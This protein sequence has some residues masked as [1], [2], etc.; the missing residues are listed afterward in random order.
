MHSQFKNVEGLIS[1]VFNHLSGDFMNGKQKTIHPF[2]S[3]VTPVV[4]LPF[5]FFLAPPPFVFRPFLHCATPFDTE[6]MIL[7]AWT[8]TAESGGKDMSEHSP[9]TNIV[10]AAIEL[11]RFPYLAPRRL[12]VALRS[13]GQISRQ[14]ARTRSGPR[15]QERSRRRD[16][17]RPNRRD[18]TSPIPTHLRLPRLSRWMQSRRHC[19]RRRPRSACSVAPVF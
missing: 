16:L 17:L 15:R 6:T 3:S 9:E 4:P 1:D 14:S 10:K 5:L 8:S 18:Q 12:T 13:P 2:S 19:P 7:A 11:A